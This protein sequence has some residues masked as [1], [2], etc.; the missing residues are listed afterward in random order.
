MRIREFFVMNRSDRSVML[1]LLLLAA[2]LLCVLWLIPGRETTE[3]TFRQPKMTDTSTVSSP[4]A[5]RPS[6]AQEELPK[7]ERFTFDPNTADSSQLLRLGLQS[8][9]VRNIYR[10]RAKGGI[11]RTKQDFARLYGL[12][13]KQYRELEPYIQISPDYQPAS[14]LFDQKEEPARQDTLR[15]PVKMKEGETLDLNLADTAA[16]RT[17]PGIGQYFAR[18]IV[19][20]GRRLGGYVS[21]DQ[22]DEIENFPTDAKQWLVISQAHPQQLR[23]NHLSVEQ[24]KQH[25]YINYYQARAIVDRRRLKGPLGSLEELRLL[26]DFPEETI[27]RLKPYVSFD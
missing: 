24:L 19:D 27:E 25:P 13:A 9:Q 1:V 21:I 6:Y 17:V 2:V 15:Y 10:Y 4:P 16:L 22:L 18:R 14:T 7:P 3:T 20:Y 8:W 5:H 11:Y 23:I 12:T 26:P